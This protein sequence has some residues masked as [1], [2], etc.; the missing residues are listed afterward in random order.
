MHLT[1]TIATGACAAT[2]TLLKAPIFALNNRLA[3]VA[4]IDFNI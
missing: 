2:Q 4:I 3:V 1:E